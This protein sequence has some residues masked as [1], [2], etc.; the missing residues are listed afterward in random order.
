MTKLLNLKIQVIIEDESQSKPLCA[1][2]QER[3]IISK[4]NC[5]RTKFKNDRVTLMILIVI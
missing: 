5:V 3:I 4:K 1:F 2:S